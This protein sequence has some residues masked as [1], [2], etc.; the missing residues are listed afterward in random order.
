MDK[1]LIQVIQKSERFIK[2]EIS[3]NIKDDYLKWLHEISKE[4]STDK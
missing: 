3:I 4:T 1:K 2:M